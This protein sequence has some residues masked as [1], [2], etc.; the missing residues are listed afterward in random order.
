MN[1]DQNDPLIL[2]ALGSMIAVLGAIAIRIGYQA[3]LNFKFELEYLRHPRLVPYN[4]FAGCHQPHAWVNVD[5][6]LRGLPPGRY[7]VCQEC[8]TITNNT[9]FMLSKEVLEHIKEANEILA[10]TAAAE[11][12]VM[13]RINALA[14]S[15]INHYIRYENMHDGFHSEA[16]LKALVQYAFAAQAEAR[17]K[18]EAEQVQKRA[19]EDRYAGW[20]KKTGGNA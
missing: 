15:M 4:E 17:D 1:I 14:D 20:S 2:I 5:L 9:E 10:K 3:Y 19:L 13:D 8:G 11:K 12:E 18:V 7:K 6:A 16:R